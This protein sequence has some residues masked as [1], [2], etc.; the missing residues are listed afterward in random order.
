MNGANDLT[1]DLMAKYQLL[2]DGK[3]DLKQAK[4]IA[5]LSG[6][7]IHCAKSHLLYNIFME[8]KQAIPFFEGTVPALAG[9]KARSGSA[10]SA[11]RATASLKDSGRSKATATSRNKPRS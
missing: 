7:I 3:L 2:K 10:R 4:Q 11:N 9:R 1:A 6:K 5:N 8:R